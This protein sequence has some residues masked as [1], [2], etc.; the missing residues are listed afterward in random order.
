MSYVQYATEKITIHNVDAKTAF[1]ANMLA[2]YIC[3]LQTGQHTDY[4][5]ISKLN[6]NVDNDSVE[7]ENVKNTNGKT[8]H[9]AK[10]GKNKGKY[11]RDNPN[12]S[13]FYGMVDNA[14]FLPHANEISFTIE[15]EA[16]CYSWA[17]YGI[18]YWK[19]FFD[20]FDC[21]SL[22]E[23][24]SYHAIEAID[25]EEE[26]YAYCYDEN[27]QGYVEYSDD[28]S[29]ISGAEKWLL[30]ANGSIIPTD[31]DDE[32]SLL[33]SKEKVEEILAAITP[34]FNKYGLSFQ[35]YEQ[36]DGELVFEGYIMNLESQDLDTFFNDFQ[37]VLTLLKSYNV[38]ISGYSN[39]L[40]CCDP[41]HMAA[42]KF[43]IDENYQLSKTYLGF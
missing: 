40:V 22:R 16:W 37:A 9:I 3:N 14:G 31:Y 28:K 13:Y 7:F 39:C 5:T 1:V 19:K 24:I 43:E 4:I 20:A 27:R 30:D 8:Y 36:G 23:N 32:T 15:F 6:L 26:A 34:Y 42:I 35:N 21:E 41:D 2:Q 10:K 18:S 33:R 38:F 11:V 25:S 12:S 29:V 17:D